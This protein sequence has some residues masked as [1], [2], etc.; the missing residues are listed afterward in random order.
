M[1]SKIV[2]LKVA[3]INP[4]QDEFGNE[5]AQRDYSLQVNKDYV[6]ELARSFGPGGEPDEHITVISDGGEYYVKAG[7]SRLEAMKLL[8]T[9]E[10]DVVL[11]DSTS[12]QAALET[13]VRTNTKKKYEDVELSRYVQQLAAFGD[14]AYVSD[15]AT[16]DVDNARRMRRACEIVGDKAEQLS[17]D[18][19]YVIPDFEG[20]DDAVEKIL[21]ADNAKWERVLADLRRE[22]ANREKVEAFRKTAED[23]GVKL[24]DEHPRTLRYAC[25]CN[26][27]SDLKADYMAASVKYKGIVG[28][29]TN[30]WYVE[31]TLHGIPLDAEAETAEESE[32][33]LKADRY[34][35][36]G[37]RIDDALINWTREQ[38]EQDGAGVLDCI[39]ALNK[40]CRA[41]AMKQWYID[42]TMKL[43][44]M[45][46]DDKNCLVL[47][48]TGYKYARERIAGRAGDLA[49]ERLSRYAASSIRNAVNWIDLHIASGWEPDDDMYELIDLAREKTASDD[50]EGEE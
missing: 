45:A 1:S 33:R 15:V 9:E 47:F 7:R 27:P 48:A 32:R 36:I 19:L 5:F 2:R 49:W 24:V 28:L 26:D 22:K 46:K 25:T 42:E 31:M 23:L 12:R 39:P 16:I 10:C 29:I 4:L 34:Q 21:K 40:A 17:L 38:L 11:D 14:D 6:E 35:A 50:M 44:P 37:G 13:V 8:G 43:F 3:D 18:R 41:I 30:S 20:D